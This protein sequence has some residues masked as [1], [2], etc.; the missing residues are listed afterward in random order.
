[1]KTF[2]A[3][4]KRVEARKLVSNDIMVSITFSTDDVS[5]LDLGKIPSD[6]VVIVKVEEEV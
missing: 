3:E 1:M 5:V 4:I 6:Q 2:I